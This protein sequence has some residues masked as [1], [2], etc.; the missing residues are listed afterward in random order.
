MKLRPFV[1]GLLSSTLVTSA[2]LALP[3]PMSDDELLAQSDLVVDATGAS[4]ACDGPTT[5]AG[6]R[7]VSTYITQITVETTVK[8]TAPAATEVVG[9]QEEY[10]QAHPGCA[11][12]TPALPEGFSGRLYLTANTDGTFSATHYNGFKSDE[13]SDPQAFL[14]CGGAGGVGGAAGTGG[15]AG[16]GATAGSGGNGGN[17]AT[18]PAADDSGCSVG[19]GAPS[20]SDGVLALAAL[21]ILGAVR[22]RRARGT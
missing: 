6:D 10:K 2:A 18:P 7:Y 3:A 4:V 8:G 19:L 15:Q 16:S 5:D 13:T 12:Y 22:R 17:D 1:P 20:A 21:A 11:G 14:D 9:Y